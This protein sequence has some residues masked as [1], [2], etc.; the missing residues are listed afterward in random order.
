M[1][2]MASMEQVDTTWVK[3]T[4]CT[5]P[6]LSWWE[7]GACEKLLWAS[8]VQILRGSTRRAF[9]SQV[10]QKSKNGWK[11]DDFLWVEKEKGNFFTCGDRELEKKEKEKERKKKKEKRKG[12]KRE[13]KRKSFGIRKLLYFATLFILQVWQELGSHSWLGA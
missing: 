3:S 2:I 7:C 5:A 10:S 12:G 6:T 9:V 13:R 11:T 8:L 1:I 4:S